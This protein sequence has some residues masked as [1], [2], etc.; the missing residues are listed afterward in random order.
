M[1]EKKI[2]E[3]SEYFTGIYKNNDGDF[4]V[5]ILFPKKWKVWGKKDDDG[6]IAISARNVSSVGDNNKIVFSSKKH[7]H[8]NIIDFILQIKMQNEEIEVKKVF[9]EEKL[10]ELVNII[11]SNPISKLRNLSFSFTKKRNE[12]TN[13]LKAENK[14][15]Q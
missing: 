2:E 11:D 6:S 14:N 3:I 10:K 13:D 4:C 7:T 12:K 15:E 1:L 8:S 5:E 9:F